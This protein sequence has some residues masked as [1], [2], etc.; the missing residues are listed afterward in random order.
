MAGHRSAEPNTLVVRMPFEQRDAMIADDPKTYYLKPHYE[1]YESVL[2]RLSRIEPDTLRDL[3]QTASRYV[4]AEGLTRR[5]SRARTRGGSGS[6]RPPR[7]S[8]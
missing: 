4:K 2:V 6:R 3:L 7:S 1:N 8:R 5:S